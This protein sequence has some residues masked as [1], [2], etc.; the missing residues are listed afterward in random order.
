MGK[1]VVEFNYAI[2][3]RV[4]A[5]CRVVG[6]ITT[7]AIDERGHVYLIATDTGNHFWAGEKMIEGLAPAE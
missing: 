7:C 4:L 6:V 3:D 1:Q 2:G 5:Q